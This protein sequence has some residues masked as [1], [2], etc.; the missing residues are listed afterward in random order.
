MKPILFRLLSM[1]QKIGRTTGWRRPGRSPVAQAAASRWILYGL[2]LLAAGAL[3]QAPVELP[4]TLTVTTNWAFSSRSWVTITNEDGGGPTLTPTDAG[5]HT[6][7]LIPGSNYVLTVS[8]TG[9]VNDVTVRFGPVSPCQQ[10]TLSAWQS[11]DHP[12]IIPSNYTQNGCIIACLAGASPLKCADEPDIASVSWHL[13]LFTNQGAIELI[14]CNGTAPADGKTRTIAWV[15][16]PFW[17]PAQWSFAGDNLGCTLIPS[18]GWQTCITSGSNS[19]TLTL[20]ATDTTGCTI[21]NVLELVD[22]GAG[23]AACQTSSAAPGGLS[24]FGDGLVINRGINVA[25]ALGQREFGSSAGFLRLKGTSP[26][27]NLY[28]VD[29]LVYVPPGLDIDVQ[30]P[31]EQVWQIKTPQ[32]L[33]QIEGASAPYDINFYSLTNVQITPA[34]EYLPT[35]TPLVTWTIDNPDPGTCTSLQITEQRPNETNRVWTYAWVDEGWQLTHPGGSRIDWF[36]ATW[37]DEYTWPPVRTEARLIFDGS[38]NCVAAQTNQYT[39]FPFGERLTQELREPAFE[40]DLAVSSYTYYTNGAA[41]GLLSEM[42]LW[43]GY[44]ECYL[45]DDQSRLV[46][47]FS[48]VGYQAPTTNTAD[49]RM[50]EHDYSTNQVAGSGDAGLWNPA[51]PRKT[52]HYWFGEPVSLEYH[53]YLPSETREIRCLR[54]DAAWNDASNLVTVTRY[55]DTGMSY[56]KIQSVRRPDGSM[57]ICQYSAGAFTTNTVLSGAPDA[58]GTNIVEGT[59]TITV[60]GPLGEVYSRS[61]VDIVSG[62]AN[63]LAI[64]SEF[65]VYGRPRKTTYLDGTSSFADYSCCGTES[66]TNREGTVTVNN[67][68]SLKRLLASTTAGLTVSN[69][70]DAAGRLLARYRIGTNGTAM[71][72]EQ[73]TFD[74]AGRLLSRTDACG[75]ETSFFE[76]CYELS[77]Q[78]KCTYFPNGSDRFDYFNRDRTLVNS[79]GSGVHGL[80]YGEGPADGGSYRMETRLNENNSSTSEYTVHYIDFVGREYMTAYPDSAFSQ[81]FYSTNGQLLKQVDPDGVTTLHQ[82]NAKGE[83][84]YSARSAS[85]G[86]S[87][88]FQNDRVTRTVSFVTNNAHGDVRVSQTYVWAT[89][90]Q[91]AATLASAVETSTDGLRSWSSS[92]GLTNQSV[93]VYAGN[94]VRYITNTAPDGTFTTSYY[95]DGRLQSITHQDAGGNQ[96]SQT[97]YALDEFGRQSTVTDARN[98]TSTLQFDA[99]DRI[100]NSTT[101]APG[102]GQSAQNTATF[103]DSVGRV[104][105]VLLPDGTTVSNEW[106]G[107]GEL[108]KTCGSRTYPV[109]YTVD[110]AGRT[111][112]M[113][114]WQDFAGDQESALT[115]WNYDSQRGFLTSKRYND[116]TGPD[117][118]YTPAGRL[119]TR[120]WAR[121]ITATY[122]TNQ[123]GETAR[124]SYSDGASGVTNA[125]DRLGR[126]AA[127]TNAPNTL[128]RSYHPSGALLT[129]TLNGITVTNTLDSLLRR[130]K[131]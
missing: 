130:V 94:G 44:W 33:A 1:G 38:S 69:V 6:A 113:K 68:D 52:T 66:L 60:T 17:G 24:R 106:H 22:V 58:Q 75:N 89:P 72:L 73:S 36:G 12:A 111:K 99:L 95:L 50:V 46:Y 107:T 5:L 20:V 56:G 21:S 125:F 101:P 55:C 3:A 4:F 97:S 83:L 86:N 118:A 90:G 79:V 63:A 127:V 103:F 64:Y 67:F 70:H 62:I 59:R 102:P 112:T 100:T 31:S 28:G 110:Y 54:P 7:W 39:V 53:V 10:L 25:F 43:D 42:T 65:D 15:T 124:I 14:A 87:I 84:E 32:A 9:C 41:Q 49:C 26:S 29:A 114:T 78:F 105:A 71:V 92:F 35:G 48:A 51:S 37:T 123:F 126:L 30:Y 88:D 96:L 45:Y 121:G 117:Y 93:T 76:G 120:T 34:G 57:D 128:L 115:T 40:S 91:D 11:Y 104:S 8:L 108:K 85:R 61:E 98:G 82:Y 122:T 18:N 19:G 74:T 116:D 109:E 119:G 13:T 131:S 16:P 129:E 2:P 27:W 81:N 80:L 77:G 23:C 47:L